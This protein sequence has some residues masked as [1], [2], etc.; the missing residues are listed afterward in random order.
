MSTVAEIVKAVESLDPDDFLKLRSALDR[1][2][3]RLWET[4]LGKA[5]ARHKKSRLTDAEI[6]DMV[7]RR[8]YP[9][10]PQ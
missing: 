7:L 6:D 4:E 3:E 2:E 9:G 5:T 10:K 1:V 8:R